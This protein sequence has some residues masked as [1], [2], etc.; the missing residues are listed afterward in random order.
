[1]P[2]KE[3]QDSDSG[4]FEPIPAGGRLHDEPEHVTFDHD[5][6]FTS[7]HD[8]TFE[9]DT[10]PMISNLPPPTFNPGGTNTLY[11][12]FLIVNAALGAGL[13]NFPKAFDEAGGIGVATAVQGVL[14]IF[15]VL[16]L[17]ILAHSAD[18]CDSAATTIQDT[19]NGA[20]GRVGKILT[21]AAV[22]V[23]TFGTTIT[24]L[25]IIGDQF[26]RALASLYGQDFCQTWYMART[27]TMSAAAILFI[28][29]LSYSQKIDFL[30][31]PSTLGVLAI[32][33][34]VGLIVY[35]YFSG[36]YPDPGPI[37]HRPDNWTDVFLVVPQVRDDL[38]Q[39]C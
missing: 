19:M 33:Y 36:Q 4:G 11:T 13:L 34:L 23:Y 27:F 6:S 17:L 20:C 35:E 14:M 22:V 29:P 18:R 38:L 28:L 12:V 26:D 25:I 24:F 5:V 39:R 21:S 15:I 2:A 7:A 30:R 16:A 1:M 10:L 31:I 32:V 9:D 8:E 3:T 37:K